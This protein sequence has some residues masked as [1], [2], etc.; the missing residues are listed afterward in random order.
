MFR[1]MP[2]ILLLAMV[3]KCGIDVWL[4]GFITAKV[5]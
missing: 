5:V 3:I 2:V 1:F 4:Q